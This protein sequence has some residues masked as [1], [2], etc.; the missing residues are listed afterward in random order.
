MTSEQTHHHKS[1]N[2]VQ[3]IFPYVMNA[4][5]KMSRSNSPLNWV[6]EKISSS[7][8]GYFLGSLTLQAK[9]DLS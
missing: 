7:S 2:K 8:P 5:K 9:V 1:C 3:L 6:G 4:N